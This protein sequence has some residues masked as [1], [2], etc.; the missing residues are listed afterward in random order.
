VTHPIDF[1][2]VGRFFAKQSLPFN[3]AV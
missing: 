2:Q 1:L 3:R